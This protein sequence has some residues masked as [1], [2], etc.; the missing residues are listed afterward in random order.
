V[1]N[2]G[3]Q[4]FRTALVSVMSMLVRVTLPVLVAVTV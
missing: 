3:V 4:E 1:G 2:V